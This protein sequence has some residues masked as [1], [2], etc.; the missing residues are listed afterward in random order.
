MMLFKLG[1]FFGFLDNMLVIRCLVGVS[2]DDG[3]V[4]FVFFMYL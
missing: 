1:R 2:N 3:I 4:Y